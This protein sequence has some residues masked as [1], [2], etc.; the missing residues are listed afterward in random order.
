MNGILKELIAFTHKGVNGKVFHSEM[1]GVWYNVPY[2]HMGSPEKGF[3]L[4]DFVL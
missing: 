2:R 3:M 1:T 4:T